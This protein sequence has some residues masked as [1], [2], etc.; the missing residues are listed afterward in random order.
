MK[1]NFL[2][3]SSLALFLSLPLAAQT[4]AD[5]ATQALTQLGTPAPTFM[6]YLPPDEC[7][8]SYT[9][10]DRQYTS[11][12]FIRQK[13]NYVCVYRCEYTETCVDHN[14]NEGSYQQPGSHRVR[15]YGYGPGECPSADQVMCTTGEWIPEGT[16]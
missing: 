8:P 2:L 14:C 7:I 5:C 12:T 9:C 16:E 13:P 1:R 11:I 3:F 6:T 4:P 15:I 10:G